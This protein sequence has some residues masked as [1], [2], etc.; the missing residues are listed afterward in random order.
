M[1]H[2][3]NFVITWWCRIFVVILCLGVVRDS[4][5]F[6]WPQEERSRNL[7]VQTN[8]VNG[9]AMDS[10]YLCAQ[11]P[12][13]CYL[14]FT[15]TSTTS[16]SVGNPA[17]PEYAHLESRRQTE[18]ANSP[19]SPSVIRL[20]NGS[21]IGKKAAVAAAFEYDPLHFQESSSSS[22]S[23]HNIGEYDS[24]ESLL[25]RKK[26]LGNDLTMDMHDN[27]VHQDQTR[28]SGELSSE[29]ESRLIAYTIRPN[30]PTNTTTGYPTITLAQLARQVLFPDWLWTRIAATRKTGLAVPA[31][32]T[33]TA[34]AST[35]T[36]TIVKPALPTVTFDNNFSRCK[37]FVFTTIFSH[38]IQTNK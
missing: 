3:W 6:K 11:S 1:E 25:F 7:S 18:F 37:L 19:P 23:H 36:A 38:E 10:A 15:S 30:M 35:T 21:M 12:A 13:D 33:A 28:S 16:K 34:A 27:N 2:C 5:Q 14:L 26:I 20:H 22:I 17:A 4:E 32:T 24:D 8:G 29:N 9:R 31:S